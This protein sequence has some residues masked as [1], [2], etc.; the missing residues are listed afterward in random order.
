[1]VRLRRGVMTQQGVNRQGNHGAEHRRD[2]HDQG[3]TRAAFVIENSNRE[4]KFMP[5]LA[6][7]YQSLSKYP[8]YHSGIII[9]HF[10]HSASPYW[11]P[12]PAPAHYQYHSAE[13]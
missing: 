7:Y 11:E 2:G 12:T 13:V 6:V 5:L 8:K 1:M 4:G 10:C 3:S 9:R